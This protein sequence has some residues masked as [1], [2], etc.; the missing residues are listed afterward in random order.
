MGGGGEITLT[1]EM[2][3][4]GIRLITSVAPTVMYTG[5]N[6]LDPVVGGNSER[7]RKLRLALSIAVD[8]EEY[9]SVF[10]NGRGLTAMHPLPPDIFGSRRGEAGINPYVFDWKDGAPRRKSVEEAR[11]LLAEAGYPGGRDAK[12]GEPLVINFRSEEHTSELQS[13]LNLVCRLLLE[14]KK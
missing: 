6:M 13:P 7:A 9:I 14:K 3:A 2:Q 4:K 1:D 12:T 11:R 10:L 5:F 8:Q